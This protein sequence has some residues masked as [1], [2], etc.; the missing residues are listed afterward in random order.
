M[1]TNKQKGRPSSGTDRKE[2]YRIAQAK[3][4]ERMIAEGKKSTTVWLPSDLM[5]TLK[6]HASDNGQTLSEVVDE[7][8]RLGMSNGA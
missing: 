2:Q 7:Y 6:K 8:I 3:F 1:M 4:R 5:E